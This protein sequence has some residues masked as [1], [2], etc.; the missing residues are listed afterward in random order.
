[1]FIRLV[2]LNLCFLPCPFPKKKSQ[3]A[4]IKVRLPDKAPT[5]RRVLIEHVDPRVFFHDQDRP[6]MVGHE[7]GKHSRSCAN[8]RTCK[9]DRQ[10]KFALITVE[11]R[12]GGYLKISVDKTIALAS[13]SYKAH[14]ASIRRSI[15][16]V[17]AAGL[18]DYFDP[19]R[20][21]LLVK[22]LGGKTPD[23]P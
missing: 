6:V 12:S 1:M 2:C 23:Q 13:L 19:K 9:H 8:N 16:K 15:Q 17:I 4:V 5:G 22:M 10:Y 21:A 14:T 11:N 20:V 7:H 3:H 18:P